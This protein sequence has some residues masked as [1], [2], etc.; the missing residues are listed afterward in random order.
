[1]TATFGPPLVFRKTEFSESVMLE[2]RMIG[3]LQS[4]LKR[5]GLPVSMTL[6]NGNTIGAGTEEHL[7]LT[8]KS[9]QALMSL[10]NPSL[11]GIARA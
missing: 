4:R 8:V 5:I 2:S 7:R 11:G 3:M 6:W 1:M 9:P 10:A